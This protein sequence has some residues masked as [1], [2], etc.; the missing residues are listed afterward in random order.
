MSIDTALRATEVLLALA[1]IQQSLEHLFASRVEFRL[2]FPRLIL[3][4]VL[5]SG[6]LTVPSLI[7]F[8]ILSLLILTHFQGVYNGGSDRMGLLVLWILLPAS[9]TPPGPIQD[10]LFGYLALQLTLS[11]FISGKVKIVNPD[12]RSGRALCDVFAFSAYPVSNST[13]RFAG[14]TTLLWVMSWAIILF[15]VL[16]PLALLNA[17]LLLVALTIG[18]LFHLA[19][20]ILFGLNRFF[21]I[22]PAA[23]PSLIWLQDRLF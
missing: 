9:I 16:F 5:L 11:Y 17:T 6:W 12:W 19:N 10:G 14:H 1:F 7:G 20:A 13:R 4:L 23:Y 3:S 8:A 22:W 21:W 18:A 15:E 2:Y